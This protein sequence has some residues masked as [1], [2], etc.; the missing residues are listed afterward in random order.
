MIFDLLYG[1]RRI[2]LF[3][4]FE[5]WPQQKLCFWKLVTEFYKE[6]LSTTERI[7]TIEIAK[8]GSAESVKFVAQMKRSGA[9]VLPGKIIA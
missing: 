1:I 3:H 8:E 2:L 4:K 7:I 5:K 9:R 6:G